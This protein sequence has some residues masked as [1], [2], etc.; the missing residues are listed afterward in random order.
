[1]LKILQITI[2]LSIYVLRVTPTIF[3]TILTLIEDHHPIFTNNSNNAQAPVESQLA[4]T[5][6]RM[7]QYGNSASVEEVARIAGCSEGSVEN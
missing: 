4:I 5:L 6:Y 3:N 1:M 2:A 7:G